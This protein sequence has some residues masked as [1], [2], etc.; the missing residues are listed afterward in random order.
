[1]SNIRVSSQSWSHNPYVNCIAPS[2]YLL[3]PNFWNLL[4]PLTQNTCLFIRN[5]NRMDDNLRWV[6]LYGSCWCFVTE[7][8]PE[9]ASHFQGGNGW[10]ERS[11]CKFITA[12]DNSNSAVLSLD[13]LSGEIGENFDKIFHN[14]WTHFRFD[15]VIL[16]KRTFD[17][18]IRIFDKLSNRKIIIF[19]SNAS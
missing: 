10:V 6:S 11:S 9:I 1:M 14:V 12:T 4:S 19:N 15:K 17:V 16:L 3:H 5:K 7:D 18:I 13:V 8:M 2:H